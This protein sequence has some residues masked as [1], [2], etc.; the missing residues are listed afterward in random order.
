M[1][2]SFTGTYSALVM[3]LALKILL[4]CF[5]FPTCALA[6]DTWPSPEVA[7]MYHHAQD[8]VAMGNY[9]DAITTYRQAIALAPHKF[10]LY[11]ELGN[12]LYTSGYYK[13]ATQTLQPLT[14]NPE[15]DAECFQLLAASLQKLHETK[16]AQGALRTGLKRFPASGLLYHELGMLNDLGE[17][18]EWGL[19][20][21]LEGIRN[22]PSFPRNYLAAAK[23]SFAAG[24]PIWGLL[25]GEIYLNMATDTTGEDTLRKMLFTGYKT[26]FDNLA[27]VNTKDSKRT[28]RQSTRR[29]FVGSVNE[30]YLSLTPVVSDGITTENLTM[31]RTRFIMDW[32]PKYGKTFPFSLFAY[33]DY[34]LRNG[35][36]DIYNEWLFGKAESPAEY[37][38]W[39]EFHPVE[40]DI[41]L[42]KQKEHPL[43]P[44]PTD[45]YNDADK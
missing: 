36:F 9:K 26:M 30:T 6:Q 34:L 7:Q 4:F 28:K 41:F 1:F 20:A 15:A 39:S 2:C 13:D 24:D 43:H 44:I 27:P 10:L 19:H 25:Y 22:D 37:K 12:A 35:L 14:E 38:A 31:V 29:S 45:F 17:N 32:L 16:K 23:A 11:K 40:M 33:H 8:Y 21:W 5:L 18:S 3:P 42:Q